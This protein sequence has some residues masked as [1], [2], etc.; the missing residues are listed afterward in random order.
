[1]ARAAEH[2][3]LIS[4]VIPAFNEAELVTRCLHET[5][6]AL[7]EIGYRY[8]VI[9]VDDGSSDGTADLARAA[10]E[11]LP[12]VRVI[13]HDVNLGKG[14]ALARGAFAALGDLVLFV[15]ADLEVHPRQLTI[16]Y[17]ALVDAGAD[18][19]IGSKLHPASRV[20]LPPGRRRL[21]VGYYL[22]VRTLF[23][24]P[25]HD[26][27]TGLKLF[28]RQA[29]VRVLPRLLVK[30]FAHD[31]EALV[32]LHRLG[33]RIVEAPVVVTRTRPFPR[34]GWRDVWWTGWDTAAIWYRT[35]LLR[36]YDRI[37]AEADRALERGLAAGGFELDR[38]PSLPRLED[39]QREPERA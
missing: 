26:T 15:D 12:R 29:L 33:Y 21:T 5:V 35:Y 28:R 36:W 23:R 4:V 20:E 25:V 6:K 3:G 18:V 10:A 7:E 31:L 22:L 11:L 34:I 24:L 30:R 1:M 27:Q 8:E 38:P 2:E 9:L 14:S 17:D 19:V 37:G 13:G 39:G 16:L 32:N